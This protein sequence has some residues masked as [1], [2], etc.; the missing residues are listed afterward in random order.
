MPGRQEQSHRVSLRTGG[1]EYEPQGFGWQ[2]SSAST[3]N[4][5]GIEQ[6]APHVWISS[7]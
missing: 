2:G 3:G 7:A 6:L 4:I 5:A 1:L